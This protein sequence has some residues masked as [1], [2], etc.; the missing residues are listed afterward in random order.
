MFEVQGG[1]RAAV[2]AR[3]VGVYAEDGETVGAIGVSGVKSEQ[4][5]A[6]ARAGIAAV[7]DAGCSP[8]DAA[9]SPIAARAGGAPV[10]R[11]CRARSRLRLLP[12]VPNKKAARPGARRGWV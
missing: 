4:D 6:V 12:C 7:T 3:H 8:F 11:A 10:V 9:P 5:A 2:D 1:D